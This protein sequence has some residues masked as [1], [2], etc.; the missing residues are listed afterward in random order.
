MA[1]SP[2]IQTGVDEIGWDT[3]DFIAA[4]DHGGRDPIIYVV[5]GRRTLEIILQDKPLRVHINP[6]VGSVDQW[7]LSLIHI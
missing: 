1:S 2:I 7:E 5:V 4:P 6:T 3:I